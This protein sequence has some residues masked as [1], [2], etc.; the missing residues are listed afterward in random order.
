MAARTKHPRHVKHAAGLAK[1]TRQA[2]RLVERFRPF[3]ENQWV[4][5]MDTIHSLAA[6]DATSEW[7]RSTDGITWED[8]FS[9]FCMGLQRFATRD[10][11]P[12]SKL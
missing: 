6:F 1:V 4:F 2:H 7:W 3:A 12:R 10:N 9:N 11:L 8:Y 5:L